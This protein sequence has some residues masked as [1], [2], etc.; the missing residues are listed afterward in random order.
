VRYDLGGAKDVDFTWEREW[1]LRLDELQFGP[2]DVTLV[3]PN[4]IVT[5][6]IRAAHGDDWHAIALSDLGVP[7][8]GSQ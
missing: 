5:A 7:I 2:K 3:V 8:L 1:R 6:E 4:R